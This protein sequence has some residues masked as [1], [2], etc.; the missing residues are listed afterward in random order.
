MS[1]SERKVLLPVPKKRSKLQTGHK[2]GLLAKLFRVLK[3]GVIGAGG[4]PGAGEVHGGRIWVE[5]KKGK[6]T[7]LLV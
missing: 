1:N 5:S 4:L 3:I 6:G 7:R 2:N